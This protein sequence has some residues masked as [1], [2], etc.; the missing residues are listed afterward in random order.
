MFK[1]P[2]FPPA[3]SCVWEPPVTSIYQLFASGQQNASSTSSRGPEK[4]LQLTFQPAAVEQATSAVQCTPPPPPPSR[5]EA[6]AQW[7]TG[8]ALTPPRPLG[9]SEACVQCATRPICLRRTVVG[10]LGMRFSVR[11]FHECVLA[12]CPLLP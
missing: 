3:W 5:T 10:A 7:T 6:A 4:R 8:D 11:G 12:P 9:F 2:P 1:T